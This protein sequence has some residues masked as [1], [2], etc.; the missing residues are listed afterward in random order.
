M[1]KED[2]LGRYFNNLRIILKEKQECFQYYKD[3][4]KLINLQKKADVR[5][6]YQKPLIYLIRFLFYLP[7]NLI[8]ILKNIN[9]HFYI[10]KLENEIDVLKLE[11]KDFQKKRWTK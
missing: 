6:F 5:L 8:R 4:I 2:N 3:T 7:I 9:N 1:I 11:I 10:T